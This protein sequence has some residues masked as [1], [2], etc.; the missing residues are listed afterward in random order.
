[1]APATKPE[2]SLAHAHETH[3]P[4]TAEPF[5]AALKA[6]FDE[7]GLC[8]LCASVCMELGLEKVWALEE[9]HMSDVPKY[10]VATLKPLYK[11]RSSAILGTAS[12]I[13]SSA[14]S[15]NTGYPVH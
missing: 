15:S 2:S 9:V 11:E 4:D 7:K 12:A 13:L 8:F 1:M 10:L 14:G 3:A 6:L 5:D